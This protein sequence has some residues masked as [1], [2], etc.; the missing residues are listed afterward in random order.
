[1]CMNEGSDWE[2][3]LVVGAAVSS[4][5]AQSENRSCSFGSRRKEGVAHGSD[6]RSEDPF[7]PIFYYFLFS[8]RSTAVV[9]RWV[10]PNRL[11]WCTRR[12]DDGEPLPSLEIDGFSQLVHT[13]GI[14]TLYLS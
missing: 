11:S 6:P 7:S 9:T 2:L 13:P 12:I 1:M 8:R 4:A 14:F 5:V 10:L 3:F